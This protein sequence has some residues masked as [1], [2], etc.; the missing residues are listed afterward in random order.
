MVVFDDMGNLPDSWEGGDELLLGDVPADLDLLEV[1]ITN[2]ALSL[3][4]RLECFAA[5]AVGCGVDEFHGLDFAP[6]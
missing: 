3:P 5:R 4:L 2:E 6:G 1:P